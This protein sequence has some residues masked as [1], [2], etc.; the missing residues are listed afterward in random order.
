MVGPRA[1][2]AL[3]RATVRQN[4]LGEGVHEWHD[5]GVV[6]A[7]LAPAS[8]HVRTQAQLR[9]VTLTHTALLP[10]GVDVDPASTRL[11]DPLTGL[12]YRVLTAT[13]TP[14]GVLVELEARREPAG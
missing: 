5:D 13:D 10:A 2:L 4:D 7:T 9:G 12:R 1:T 11:R 6:D 14:R 3:E 8:A